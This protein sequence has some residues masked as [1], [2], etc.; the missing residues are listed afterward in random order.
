MKKIQLHRNYFLIALV[1]VVLITFGIGYRYYL[2]N[3]AKSAVTENSIRTVSVV[4]PSQGATENSL[5]FPGKLEAYLNAPI[6]SR[7]NGYLKNWHKDIGA[8]VNKGELLGEIESPEVE[9]QLLQAKSDVLAAKSQEKLAKVTY[10]RWKQL[11]EDDAVSQQDVDQRLTEFQSKSA[12]TQVALSNLQRAKA[13]TEYLS[14]PAPFSG[15]LTERNTDVGA[16]VSASGGKPLF[17]IANIDKLRLYV[18]IPQI[19]K[20]DIQQGLA[21]SITAPEFPGKIFKASV[22]RSSNA[23]D[24]RSGS[25]LVEIEMPNPKHEL[26]A[27]EYVKVS[28]DLP[29]DHLLLRVPSS[30]II[31]RKEGVSLATIDQEQ[32]VVFKSIQLGRD[33]GQEVEIIGDLDTNSLVINNPSETIIPGE[34]VK[35]SLNNGA[36][37]QKK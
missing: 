37:E 35:F 33:F 34:K 14:I 5:A 17:V 4:H 8:T 6:Y 20:N 18:N 3:K 27:G 31:T 21:A 2:F 10:D 1:V 29:S 26:T 22:I 23:V 24:D 28:I 16:L 25:V 11:L 36:V 12:L 9:Q 7:V 15:I 32:K 13:F 19:F 30:A